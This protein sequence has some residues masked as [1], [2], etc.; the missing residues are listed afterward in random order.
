MKTLCLFTLTGLLCLPSFAQTTKGQRITSGE[1][2]FTFN[3]ASVRDRDRAIIYGVSASVNRG[4]FFKDNW[5]IGYGIGVN[6][7][8]VS[9]D[10]YTSPAYTS[11]GSG[12]NAFASVFLR[13]YWPVIDRLSLYAGGGINGY[14]QGFR[15]STTD[16]MPPSASSTLSWGIMP[17]GQIG[18]LYTLSNRLALEANI[19]NS[20]PTGVDN[21]SFGLAFRTGP[22]SQLSLGIA[23][24]EAPQIQKGRWLL[25]ASGSVTGGRSTGN[26]VNPSTGI[27]SDTKSTASV[28]LSAGLFT[29]NNLLVGLAMN[30]VADRAGDD[31]APGA[32]AYS[33]SFSPFVRSYVGTH[34]LRPF[35]EGRL[36][37][38]ISKSPNS[39]VNPQY[40]GA[41]I[42]LGLAYMVGEHF[43]IQTSLGSL[44]GRYNWYPGY[45]PGSRYT[46]YTISATATTRANI[47]VAYSL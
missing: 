3:R 44:D 12:I 19:S 4:R 18:A 23:D 13:R 40:A 33:M 43:I 38:G 11:S 1:V 20:F 42:G 35:V 16:R 6:Y 22:G 47:S 15:A 24:V 5:L 25:G 17:M 7:S 34:R 10:Y 31:A 46:N 30:Y 26:F 2:G 45:D 32:V 29:R 37:Y 14:R 9:V 27:G 39:A 8:G 21:I 36:D 41:G 28:G